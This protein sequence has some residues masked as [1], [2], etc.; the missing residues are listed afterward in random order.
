[1]ADRQENT[2]SGPVLDLEERVRL[3]R[4]VGGFPAGSEG[5]VVDVWCAGRALIELGPLDAPV[6]VEIDV[7]DLDPAD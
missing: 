4:P 1:V 5:T 6:V 7:R 3:L 2:G